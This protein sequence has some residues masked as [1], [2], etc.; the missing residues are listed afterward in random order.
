[1]VVETCPNCGS[2]DVRSNGRPERSERGVDG[3]WYEYYP[4]KCSK[5]GYEWDNMS[6]C[7]D[8]AGDDDKVPIRG[9]E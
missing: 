8:D 3:D 1:M 9:K 4:M 5:C 7:S 6:K 2:P